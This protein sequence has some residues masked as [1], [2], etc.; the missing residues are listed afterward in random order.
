MK[1]TSK[2]KL[3][4]DKNE[5]IIKYK[6]KKKRKKKNTNKHFFNMHLYFATIKCSKISKDVPNNSKDDSHPKS[7]SKNSP[8]LF[9][10]I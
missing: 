8:V 5:E 4:K 10:L 6:Q 9:D 3:N 2:L 7:L 1:T